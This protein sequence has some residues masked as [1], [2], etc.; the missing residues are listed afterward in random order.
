MIIKQLDDLVE[1]AKSMKEKSRVA[2]VAAEEEH[3][4]EA[5]SKAKQDGMI[6]P[7]LVGNE[8]KI[9]GILE[10]MGENVSNYEIISSKSPEESLDIVVKLINKKEADV[11]M[12]GKIETGTL[13]KAVVNKKNQLLKGRQ[14]SLVG[15]YQIERYHKLLALSDMGINTYPDLNTKKDILLN[16]V[17]LL[18]KVDIK[19]PRVA[20]LAAIE[21]VNPK[22]PETVD[23]NAL[24]EM[25]KKGE[26]TGC[27]VEGPVSLDLAINKESARI[28]N[29]ENRV[30][31]EAD[32]LL[33]PDIV[34]GNILA[35]CLTELA[36]AQVAGTVMGAEV[37]I[38]LTSRSA[39][40]SDKYYS[41][42]LAACAVRNL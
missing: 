4:L 37:P 25:N 14:I 35:K 21:K 29:Y 38:I 26:I 36:G 12:K 17:E 13:M 42:A 28:K 2:V 11:I 5:I 22:M 32:L 31:G 19:N 39:A 24:Y 27:Y 34:S 9:Q 1:Q 16:A 8:K 10:S 30:A 23:A 6:S 33:V 3:T 7:M 20:V 18:Q 15:I 41:I 40:A